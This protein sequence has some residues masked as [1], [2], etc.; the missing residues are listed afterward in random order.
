MVPKEWMGFFQALLQASA[1]Y[2]WAKQLLESG[3]PQLLQR[4]GDG[5]C[6]LS[7]GSHSSNSEACS[8]LLSEPYFVR[9]IKEALPNEDTEEVLSSKKRG[10]KG[11]A[12]TPVVDSA[13]RR[14]NRVRANSNGFKMSTY[15]VKNCL[16]CSNGPQLCPLFLYKRLGPLCASSRKTSWR[17]NLF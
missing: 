17:S 13:I 15:R 5:D 14:S 3:F 2:R 1:H 11:K 12:V 8:C 9:E 6:H 4:G 10:R 16:G 7:L